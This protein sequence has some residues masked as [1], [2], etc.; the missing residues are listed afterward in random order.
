MKTS[1]CF[2]ALAFVLLFFSSCEDAF[3]TNEHHAA[4]DLGERLATERRFFTDEEELDAIARDRLD[5][6][7]WRLAEEF[8]WLWLDRA[9][10][11]GEYPKGSSLMDLPIPIYSA[12]GNPVLYEF[13]VVCSG[14]SIAHI[15]ATATKDYPCP[16]LYDS[17]SSG[18]YDESA[19]EF[20]ESALR[21]C[22]G[23][24]MVDNG[25]PNV[26]YG[27][28]ESSS[29]SGSLRFGEFFDVST[30]RKISKGGLC[31][32][33]SYYE[34]AEE[35]PELALE[36]T[37]MLKAKSAADAQKR[38]ADRFWAEAEKSRGLIA[39][40][41][42]LSAKS[43]S[44]VRTSL[45]KSSIYDAFHV[46]GG[47]WHVANYGACGAV[48]AGFVLDYLLANRSV[49]SSWKRLE[50]FE[51]KKEALYKT[52]FIGYTYLGDLVDVIGENG[53][54]VTLPTDIGKAISYFS[55][56]RLSLSIYS[57]P[58][59]SINNNLP[60]IS[61]R[62]LSSGGMHYRNVI[63]YRQMGWGPF[64]WPEFKILDLVDS[65]DLREGSWET[66]IP[67]YHVANWNVV[68]K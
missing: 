44:S 27:C 17:A 59:A 16:I 46:N 33:V 10:Q 11:S 50:E 41:A 4:C 13:R 3:V 23:I 67:A 18:Y 51:D 22:K 66:F 5:A 64:S 12:D 26:V 31:H 20:F 45:D 65:S 60:G 6:V 8:A 52:M 9:I 58:K 56:Y 48:S 55:D 68:K 34:F 1:F 57:Y 30:H 14:E 24:R 15:T 40:K 53:E 38:E 2:Y 36:D 39:S 7:D 19:F 61:L 62:T 21:D 35:N 54:A 32:T 43:D 29:E 37:D 49:H 28:F 25:Y 42:S 63:A 47:F